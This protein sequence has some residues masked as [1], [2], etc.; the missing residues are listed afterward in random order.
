MTRT[1]TRIVLLSL[2]DR[3]PVPAIFVRLALAEKKQHHKRQFLLASNQ[4][5]SGLQPTRLESNAEPV[6]HYLE[7][8]MPGR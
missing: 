1:S 6:Y 3:I 7:D 8:R 2:P 4:A 5:Y